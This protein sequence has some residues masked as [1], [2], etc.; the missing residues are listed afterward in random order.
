VNAF[1]RRHWILSGL[2]GIFV[3]A[4]FIAL[5]ALNWMFEESGAKYIKSI[6]HHV[7]ASSVLLVV[8]HPDDEQLVTGLLI[9]AGQDGAIRTAAVTATKGEAGTP[10]P[11]ISRLEDLGSVR[12]AEALKNTWALGVDHHDVLDFPD[13]G[14]ESVPLD[15]LTAAVRQ[16]MILH[17][18]DLV[19]TFW[20]ESGFSDH[21]D[22]KRMGLASEMVIGALRA[23]PAD[24]YS[25]PRHIAYALAP[26]RMMSRFAGDTG[27]RVVANQP[28]ANISQNGEAWAKLRGWKIHASQQN[29]VWHAYGLPA[30]LVHRLYDKEH[31]YLIEAKDI[32]AR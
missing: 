4:A 32:P 10:L 17:K 23:N 3:L 14:V 25:G 21:P 24:G 1:L 7:E 31:Y 19:V 26:T 15:E 5:S 16:R 6:A 2:V 9:R 28:S 27:R 12:K 13:S 18:P 11:Q 30:W 22:H 20:P 29:Y 8:A